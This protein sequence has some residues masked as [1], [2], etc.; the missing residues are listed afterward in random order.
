M[1]RTL[2]YGPSR[3]SRSSRRRPTSAGVTVSGRRSC[4]LLPRRQGPTRRPVPTPGCSRCSRRLRPTGPQSTTWPPPP[5]KAGAAHA[6]PPWSHPRCPCACPRRPWAPIA[7]R[8]PPCP[9]Y[10]GSSTVPASPR[11]LRSRT[12]PR[13]GSRTPPVRPPSLR[14]P[15]GSPRARRRRPALACRARTSRS[16]CWR[17]RRGWPCQASLPR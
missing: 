15:S 1:D 10:A 4:C 5:R 13:A 3:S 11:A 2:A 17:G 14:R 7:G 16:R 6:R 12:A 9:Q 8:V